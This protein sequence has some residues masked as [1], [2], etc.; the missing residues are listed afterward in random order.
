MDTTNARAIG[1]CLRHFK[2]LDESNAAVHCATVK[3]SPVTFAVAQCISDLHAE[4]EELLFSRWVLEDAKDVLSHRGAY[5]L[6]TGR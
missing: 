5:E 2:T 4:S 1:W 3:Y 6:D